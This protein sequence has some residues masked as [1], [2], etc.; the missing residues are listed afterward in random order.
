MFSLLLIVGLLH[1]PVWGA[2]RVKS[3]PDSG[4]HW[5]YY[6]SVSQVA[7][8]RGQK[9]EVVHILV[10]PNNS[11]RTSE[12]LSYQEE[13]LVE[14]IDRNYAP[15]A[16]ALGTV[17]LS[18]VFPRPSSHPDLYTHALDR[19]SLTTNLPGLERLDLQL[20]AMVDDAT[21]RLESRGWKVGGKI[22]IVGFSASGMF[23]NRFTFL[24]P[25]HV[26]AAAIGSPG[27]WPIAP[28]E[29][30]RNRRLRY[31]IGIGDVEELIGRP[32]DLAELRKVPLLIFMGDRDEN[33][34]VDY[35]D[36]YEE[37]DR[38]LIDRLFGS[39]PVERWDDAE[40][41]YQSAGLQAEFKLYPGIAHV[42]SPDMIRDVTG[43]LKRNCGVRADRA[44][45]EDPP[46][47]Q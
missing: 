35:H 24:H 33:D 9:G 3:D 15:L 27:G 6:L 43:F 25:G 37:R 10:V 40:A 42:M 30:F 34:S 12:D 44:P 11:G 14:A 7:R 32:I 4:F 28:V 46:L 47:E 20:I 38:Q 22:L 23:A 29:A 1:L 17:L 16:D 31:P 8:E 26:L 19:D 41:L 18:P 2:V 39:R 5:P 13:H 45:T 21:Q 36:G